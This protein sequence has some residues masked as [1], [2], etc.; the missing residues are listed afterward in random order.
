MKEQKLRKELFEAIKELKGQIEEGMKYGVPHIFGEIHDDRV[1]LVVS[2]VD[3]ELME[4]V[5]SRED[6]LVFICPAE[7]TDV[8][9]LFMNVWDLI[10]GRSRNAVR[11]GRKIKGN[12]KRFMERNGFT[13]LW[14]NRRDELSGEIQMWVKR[15]NI[16]YS[17]VLRRS[18][19]NEFVVEEMRRI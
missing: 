1:E 7:D 15:G 19:E 16:R 10:K 8:A 2:V 11:P 18:G 17:I 6:G 9:R 5:I 14:M 3:G 4:N 13:I 12:V